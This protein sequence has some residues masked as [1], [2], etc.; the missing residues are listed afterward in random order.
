MVSSYQPGIAECETATF[1]W[2][3]AVLLK[4]DLFVYVC[5]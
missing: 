5:N 1:E 4:G 2:R 3:V